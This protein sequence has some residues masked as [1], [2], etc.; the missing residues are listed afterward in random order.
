MN[1]TRLLSFRLRLK[2]IDDFDIRVFSDLVQHVIVA[3][4]S[5]FNEHFDSPICVVVFADERHM[6]DWAD[7]VEIVIVSFSNL[8]CFD[9]QIDILTH[10]VFICSDYSEKLKELLVFLMISAKNAIKQSP[11]RLTLR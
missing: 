5:F 11:I 4:T 7:V 3:L 9:V 10:S 6:V 2:D 8:V 1:C